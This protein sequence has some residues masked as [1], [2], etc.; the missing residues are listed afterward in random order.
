MN[1]RRIEECIAASESGACV[2]TVDE[3]KN[4]ERWNYQRNEHLMEIY[5][6]GEYVVQEVEEKEM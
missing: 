2:G 5:Y 4:E 3:Q 1:W 6:I